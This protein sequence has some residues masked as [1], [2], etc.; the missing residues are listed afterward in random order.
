MNI[1]AIAKEL[2]TRIAGRDFDG[3]VKL[4]LGPEG[5]LRL[6]GTRVVREDGDADCTLRLSL[7]DLQAMI[8]GELDPTQ[9]FMYGR[10]EVEG[11]LSVVMA[12][13]DLL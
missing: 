4:D 6:D 11:D 8:A 13:N 1:D 7:A 9:A 10:L 12:L 5:I 3:S 2:E